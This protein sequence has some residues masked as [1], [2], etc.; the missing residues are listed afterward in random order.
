[1]ADERMEELSSGAG[2]LFAEYRRRVEAGEE[3]DLEAL[4]REH[5]ELA[6]ELRRLLAEGED[7]ERFSGHPTLIPTAPPPGTR[8]L[9]AGVEIGDFRLL[10]LL[11][12]GAAGEVWE[13][14]EPRLERRVALK[15]LR[16]DRLDPRAP[17]RLEHE[18]RAL[19][20]VSHPGVVAVHRVGQSEGH[21][22][23]AQEL[24]P[25]G[26][27]LHDAIADLRRDE[28]RGALPADHVERT[29]ALVI[30]IC[31]GLQVAHEAGIVHR[32]V[33]PSNVLLTPEGRPKLTDFGLARLEDAT[34]QTRTGQVLGT[35][36][37]MSPE[38]LRAGGRVDARSDVFGAGVL[39]YELLTLQRPFRGDSDQQLRHAILEQ[40]PLDPRKL[41]SRTPAQLTWIV[42][43]ALEKDPRRRYA[44]AAELAGDLRRLLEHRPVLA[45]RPTP[46]IRA[47]K[48]A[49]R[50]PVGTVVAASAGALVVVGSMWLSTELRARA[51]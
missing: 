1:M 46:W 19:A 15:L 20:R 40:E 12:R 11:D 24:V 21:L 30:E 18:G 17:E 34:T 9:S 45:R 8:P 33:K 13:A 7:S 27:T 49:R 2:D 47:R 42:L 31:E 43:K 38:H 51:R 3:P 25:D 35:L 32:D 48:W 37:Y 10:R 6:G 50:H 28:G 22:W 16:A 41:R 5:P 23:I 39:L 26:R 29:A 14:D 44:S 4:C 36:A